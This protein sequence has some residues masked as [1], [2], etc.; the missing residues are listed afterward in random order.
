MLL[1]LM[2]AVSNG[3]LTEVA[4][5]YDTHRIDTR[6]ESPLHLGR[7]LKWLGGGLESFKGLDYSK[8]IGNWK[9]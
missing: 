7:D 2:D 3:N 9:V 6:T 1:T 4:L 5:L 8:E